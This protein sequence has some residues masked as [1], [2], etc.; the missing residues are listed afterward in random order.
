MAQLINYFHEN[1]SLIYVTTT[2]LV[3]CAVCIC[4]IIFARKSTINKRLQNKEFEQATRELYAKPVTTNEELFLD[5][6][7]NKSTYA[8]EA[9]KDEDSV[10]E[11]ID[12]NPTDVEADNVE[13]L[14]EKSTN[15][16]I[17]DDFKQTD[18]SNKS[19][20][21]TPKKKELDNGKSQIAVTAT[22][23][24][25]DSDLQKS[26]QPLKKVAP[27]N[28]PKQEASSRYAGKWLIFSE[29]GRFS[30]NLLASNGEV[31]LRSESYSSLNGVK[32]GIETIKNNVEKN[33]FAISVDK[34][35]KYS[36]KLYTAQ[37]R[38]L[39]ISEG[40]SSKALCES[41]IESVKRFSKTAIIEVKKDEEV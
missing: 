27:K 9:T 5:P 37:T 20:N 6:D 39:C 16:P 7:M 3:S 18:S 10:T 30:A 34:K 17:N 15:K 23:A 8:D 21:A 35:E 29:N 38:L 1:P 14:D 33:N 40:Y 31:L 11:Q 2:M 36:F 24:N 12:D 19:N 32:N 22:Q 41:A 28:Q 25:C 13:V 26:K 4:F